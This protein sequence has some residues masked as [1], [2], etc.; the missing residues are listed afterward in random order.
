MLKHI[1]VWTAPTQQLAQQIASCLI[2]LAFLMQRDAC[3]G[4]GHIHPCSCE[5]HEE[6]AV[7]NQQGVLAI[8]CTRSREQLSTIWESSRSAFSHSCIDS[9]CPHLRVC[10]V[11]SCVASPLRRRAAEVHKRFT[12]T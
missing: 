10:H 4:H 2:L 7:C 5:A 9:A 8:L 6:R 1:Q 12:E 11:R 3:C